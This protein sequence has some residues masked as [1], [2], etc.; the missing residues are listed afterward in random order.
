MTWTEIYIAL[1]T[2]CCYARRSIWAE[3]YVIWMKEEI[4]IKESYCKDEKLKKMISKYGILGENGEKYLKGIPFIQMVAPYG[5]VKP[6]ESY[7]EDK[8]ATDWEIV[9][10]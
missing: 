5:I 4:N 10:I 2:K 9:E 8:V 1:K 7:P 3:G 6:Y